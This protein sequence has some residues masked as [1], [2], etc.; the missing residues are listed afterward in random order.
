M[1]TAGG[2]ERIGR[3]KL[4]RDSQSVDHS[5]LVVAILASVAGGGDITGSALPRRNKWYK[6]VT[7]VD[8]TRWMIGGSGTSHSNGS[9]HGFI[10]E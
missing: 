8:Q 2:L 1:S 4:R 3:A 5:Q 10:N 7:E 6:V 9:I